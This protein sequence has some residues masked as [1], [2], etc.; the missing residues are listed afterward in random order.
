MIVRCVSRWALVCVHVR[1]STSFLSGN[2][3]VDSQRLV[4]SSRWALGAYREGWLSKC[5]KVAHC[6]ASVSLPLS[7][8]WG[9]VTFAGVGM[10][11]PSLLLHM[12]GGWGGCERCVAGWSGGCTGSVGATACSSQSFFELWCPPAALSPE[13]WGPSSLLSGGW[14]GRLRPQPGLLAACLL[15]S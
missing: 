10:R 6:P 13:Y 11:S 12:A 9:H 15:C 1:T 4:L 8:F 3:A 7:S 14:S 2:L 5:G